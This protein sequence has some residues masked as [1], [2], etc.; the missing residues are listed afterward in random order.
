MCL[1]I[2][3]LLTHGVVCHGTGEASSASKQGEH[4]LHHWGMHVGKAA[5]IRTCK[6]RNGPCLYIHTPVVPILLPQS[7]M[8]SVSA[9]RWSLYHFP[10]HTSH[11][12]ASV[13]P[14][15]KTTMPN[16]V[17]E[18]KAVLRSKCQLTFP[19]PIH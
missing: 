5:H 8:D 18:A 16:P 4:Q 19:S 17:L 3:L 6:P 7:L 1:K 10:Q 14:N 15:L 13:F 11:F 9:R 2:Q 12:E